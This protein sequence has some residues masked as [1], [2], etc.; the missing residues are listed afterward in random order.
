MGMEIE[1]QWNEEQRS[2]EWRMKDRGMKNEGQWNEE[3]RP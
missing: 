2:G 3:Q 1:G